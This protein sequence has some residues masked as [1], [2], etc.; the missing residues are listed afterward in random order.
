MVS[1][2]GVGKAGDL[3]QI[4]VLLFE[5]IVGETPHYTDNMDLLYRRI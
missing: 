4:G 2:K 5:L 1:K 3:Y